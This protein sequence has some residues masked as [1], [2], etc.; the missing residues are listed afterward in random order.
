[1]WL[2]QCADERE[3]T[4]PLHRTAYGG[5]MRTA[6]ALIRNGA[7]VCAKSNRNA[8]TPLHLAAKAGTLVA[9]H[10]R[11]PRN[12]FAVADQGRLMVSTGRPLM[13]KLL[14]ESGAS[15]SASNRRG[16]VPLAMATE[17]ETL[18]LLLVS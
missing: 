1:M 5:Y 15:M 9:I 8:S 16:D 3:G 11:L 6:K 14:I 13:C 18:R 4:T 7:N 17:R 12:H 2:V 10:L